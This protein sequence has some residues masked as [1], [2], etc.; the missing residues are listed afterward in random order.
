MRTRTA[1]PLAV[2]LSLGAAA[3]AQ[4]AELPLTRAFAGTLTPAPGLSTQACQ[5]AYRP[6]AP[7][8]ATKEI[9]V[10]PGVALIDAAMSGA[11][12]GDVD[13]AI[14]DASGRA[15]AAAA[16]PDSQEVAQGWTATGGTLR[17]Q[18]CRTDGD[19]RAVRLVVERA[20]LV[21]DLTAAQAKA[22]APQLVTVVAPTRADRSRVAALGL[23]L[24]EHSGTGGVGVVLHGAA[25][26]VKLS[27]AGFTW[28]VLVKD[29]VADDLAARRAELTSTRARTRA[30]GVRG[31]PS[32]R[33]GTYRTLADYESE[34]KKLALENPGLVKL[35][36]LKNKTLG[37]RDVLGI[38]ITTDVNV[39][40]GKPGFLNMGVHHA[41]EWP[42]G[43]NAMEW[44]YELVNG[45]KAGDARITNIVRNSRSYVVPIVNPDGFEASRSAGALGG[46]DGG[47][48]E[49]VE[50]T[51][52]IVAGATTGGEYRRKNC[53]VPGT[54][55][56]SC[57]TSAGLAEPGVDPNRNY[58]GLWGGPGADATNVAAQTYRGDGPF[59]E[60]ETQNVKEL[61]GSTQIMSLITNHTTAGLVLR[62]PGLAS[63][64]DPVDENRGYKALG[65]AMAKENGYFSQKSYEL[66][67]T[68]GGTE[69]W[70]YNTAG[71]YGFTFEIFCDAPNYATGDCDDPSF[72]PTYARVVQ[73]YEGTSAQADHKSDP[74][75]SAAA[76]FGNVAGYDGKGNRE[77]YKIAAES[78]I[79]KSRHAVL[80][81]T[82]APGVTLRLKK[83]FKTETFPQPQDS[84]P[85][86]PILFD[87]Q[88]QSTLEVGQGGQFTWH[89]NPSTRPIVGKA[90]GEV[91][92]GAPSPPVTRS[93]GPQGAADDP[94]GDGA[95][96]PAPGMGVP[97]T[98]ASYNDHP[99][100]VPATGDNRSANVT[101]A[102]TTPAS[103]YDIALYE[104][105]NG[106]GVSQDTEKQVATSAQGTTAEEALSIPK[107]SL[108]PGR[109]YVLRVTN[110]VA[111][112]PYTVTIAYTGPE[113]YVAPQ[114]E[115]YTLTCER[116]GSVLTTQQVTIDRGEVKGL[117]LGGA[118][119]AKAGTALPGAVPAACVSGAGFKSAA[120]RARGRGVR[121]AF[122]RNVPQKATVSVFQQSAGRTITGERLVA[123]F[124]GRAAS[125]TWNGKANRGTRALGDG[126]YLV[127]YEVGSGKARDTRRI[128]L[129]RRKGTFAARADSY[130]RASCDALPSFKLER[131]VFG[132]AK[133]AALKAS[134]TLRNSAKVTLTVLRG[135]KVVKT[136]G[137]T[138]RPSKQTQRVTLPA[139]G[140]A[141]GT[142]TV[143]ISV[144]VTVG[145]P[146]VSTLT[147]RRL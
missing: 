122:A 59:S 42:A 33:T 21:T 97:V 17:L 117:V 109:K 87:D 15:I 131:P 94:N 124:A 100:T 145:P 35:T 34:L 120:A 60:K 147:A 128:V 28:N 62:A 125:F 119:A 9:T 43:E 8:V 121:F 48:D 89:V 4:A 76:P 10:L 68:T 61:V 141:R 69:D 105:A 77:A 1:L 56:G 67:D 90:R 47:R 107:E 135:K 19:T 85:D 106:D 123:R 71:G 140:L 146:L 11:R 115:A 133:N 83:T 3:P 14:F 64:G 20:A 118:C 112:E 36:T 95:A 38:E 29:L 96:V 70:T 2:L 39:S 75:R 136:F 31:L 139:K 46:A 102:W 137:P 16:S 40:D 101:V 55:I 26:R 66:Y 81:G 23:D 18:A 84:G 126:F 5:A 130:R 132:G 6:G 41:R 114:V 22:D 82:A 37:G 49:S 53:H 73:E 142:Y 129:E 24:T 88:L 134:F 25:D 98:S 92:G 80:E 32:G 27:R 78:A 12:G 108:A 111:V 99:F 144:P 54:Q 57:L 143:R 63:L 104:D 79:D 44:A 52:Y 91:G 72:H 30:A 127:R 103:D 13:L 74:G 50:D 110:F 113:P 86:K 58:G 7:G 51:V 93:G 45:F 116:G 138:T 65:D